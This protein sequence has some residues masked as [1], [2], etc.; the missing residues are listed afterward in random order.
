MTVAVVGA[1][2][3]RRTRPYLTTNMFKRMRR[4]VNTDQLVPNGSPAD[5]DAELYGYISSAAAATDTYCLQTLA[6]TTD[7][8]AGYINVRRDGTVRIHPRFTPVVAV[9]SFSYGTNSANMRPMSTLTGVNVERER[10]TVPLYMNSLMTSSQGPIQFGGVSAPMDQAWC[11]YTYT[12]GFPVCSLA[13]PVAVGDTLIHVDDTTGIVPGQTW[14]TVYAGQRE[15]Q[16]LAGTVSTAP[17]GTIVGVGPGTVA[18]PPSP[19]VV[20]NNGQYPELVAGLPNDVIEANVLLTRS[21]IK[22]GGGGNIIASAVDTI[23]ASTAQKDPYG[24]GPDWLR[25]LQM[26]TSYMAPREYT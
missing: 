21:L 7:T 16:F 5:Q 17:V 4:G 10:F 2:S 15:F 11:Q 23:G 18:C 13:A 12:N 6:A 25:G 19:F 20:S 3:Q 1:T 24:A 26:L 22:T 14:L 8:V 9:N